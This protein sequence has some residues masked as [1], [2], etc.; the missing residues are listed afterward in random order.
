MADIIGAIMADITMIIITMSIIRN[1]LARRTT[2]MSDNPK[3]ADLLLLRLHRP[4]P[5][6]LA[7]NAAHLILPMFFSV[8]NAD[9]RWPEE[10]AILHAP[11][12]A[13]CSRPTLNFVDSAAGRK[14]N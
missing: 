2:V 12:A 10:E 8:N 4:Q 7:G 6:H 11:A 13:I 9:C 14:R 3:G 5:P 1:R